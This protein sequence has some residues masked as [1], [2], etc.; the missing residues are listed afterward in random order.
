MSNISFQ[1]GEILTAAKL[2]ELVQAVT[3]E[4][5]G[6][7]AGAEVR[8]GGIPVQTHQVKQREFS[9]YLPPKHPVYIDQASPHWPLA[10]GQPGWFW[11]ESAKPELTRLPVQPEAGQTLYINTTYTPLGDVSSQKLELSPG[12]TLPWKPWP[13]VTGYSSTALGTVQK[14][15][16][17]AGALSETL[18]FFDAP[19]T[20]A[21]P[22]VFYS[23]P[24]TGNKWV[25]RFPCTLAPGT[26][27][28]QYS[29]V[30]KGCLPTIFFPAV[31]TD[32][33]MILRETRNLCRPEL[34]ER[35][36]QLIPRF[37][38]LAAPTTDAPLTPSEEELW[39]PPGLGEWHKVASAFI[40]DVELALNLQW[41]KPWL[42]YVKLSTKE[43]PSLTPIHQTWKRAWG[44]P[45]SPAPPA[46]FSVQANDWRVVSKSGPQMQVINSEM[47]PAECAWLMHEEMILQAHGTGCVLEDEDGKFW[48]MQPVL[49]QAYLRRQ[50]APLTGCWCVWYDDCW[51]QTPWN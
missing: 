48:T 11:R 24:S 17:R 8:R 9:A 15:N 16:F 2:N 7:A 51:T 13:C 45:Q 44:L 35:N 4:S 1:R 19:S 3:G 25:D 28:A 34:P 5:S 50:L 10:G 14:D 30:T 40:G 12:S 46:P 49:F 36:V 39:V 33:G 20:A 31:Q 38:L 26:Y 29:L 23:A 18:R 22:M 37:A 41:V 43:V 47:F 32:G 21:R 42:A 6:A 27:Y